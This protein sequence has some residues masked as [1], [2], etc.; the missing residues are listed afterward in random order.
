MSMEWF[1]WYH[2]T[3]SDP[4]ITV[5]ARRA[6]QPKVAVIG[7]WA[8]L[9]E[10]ASQATPRGSID[11]FD[12]ENVAA[13]LDLDE[14]AVSAIVQAMTAKGM[15]SDGRLTAW[16]ARQ[17]RRED[18]SAER[19][20]AWRDKQKEKADSDCEHDRTQPNADE[21]NQTLDKRRLD[22]IREEELTTTSLSLSEFSEENSSRDIEVPT[23][24]AEGDLLGDPKPAKA[25]KFTTKFCKEVIDVYH[26][27]LPELPRAQ[28][29]TTERQ[30][31]MRKHFEHTL[32]ADNKTGL[33]PNI[34]NWRGYFR[35]VRDDDWAMGRVDLKNGSPPFKAK[36]EYLISERGFSRIHEAHQERIARKPV[37]RHDWRKESAVIS[38]CVPSY[39][40]ATPST[41]VSAGQTH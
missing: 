30:R 20:K 17:P 5:I 39:G 19:A 9:L 6:K 29:L 23:S 31:L 2:N 26:E 38:P 22:E 1:R 15:I 28:I 32:T 35:A 41:P 8:A 12:A 24:S 3:T 21:L 16:D 14:D 25:P 34:E 40:D 37:A 18:G 4:K 13:G 10:S 36:L 7:V 27:T 33:G 11:N